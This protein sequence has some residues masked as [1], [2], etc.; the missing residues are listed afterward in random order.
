MTKYL[1]GRVPYREDALSTRKGLQP[2]MRES[3]PLI[4]RLYWF[5]ASF[6]SKLVAKRSECYEKGPVGSP[7]T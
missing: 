5:L 1:R 4:L 3:Q 2:T 6:D 7:S